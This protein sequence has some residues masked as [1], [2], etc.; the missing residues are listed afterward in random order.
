MS[1]VAVTSLF[2][3]VQ[4]QDVMPFVPFPL[5]SQL[6]GGGG[7]GVRLSRSTVPKRTSTGKP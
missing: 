2:E 3:E 1:T 7:D 5:L 6:V 4:L